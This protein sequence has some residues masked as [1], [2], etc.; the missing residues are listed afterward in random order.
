M[1]DGYATK[2]ELAKEVKRMDE[3]NSEQDCEIKENRDNIKAND[4]LT[5]ELKAVLIRVER[6]VDRLTG[7]VGKFGFLIVGSLVFPIVVAAIV[8]VFFKG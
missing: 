2:L 1:T 7:A 4:I 6:S 8:F 5:G 3:K